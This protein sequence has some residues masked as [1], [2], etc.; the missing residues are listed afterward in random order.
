MKTHGTAR[1]EYSCVHIGSIQNIDKLNNGLSRLNRLELSK[2]NQTNKQA[3]EL[4]GELKGLGIKYVDAML[5]YMTCHSKSN[6]Q[7]LY[8]IS[9]VIKAKITEAYNIFPQEPAFSPNSLSSA[10]DSE[11]TQEVNES[12]GSI[13]TD[14]FNSFV[15]S[16]AFSD[17][18]NHYHEIERNTATRQFSNAA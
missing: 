6:A 16:T 2:I 15:I 17:Y 8:Q 4:L 13:F 3:Q 5:H 18:V 12:I 14:L 1:A 11:K 10:A 9:N 7:N